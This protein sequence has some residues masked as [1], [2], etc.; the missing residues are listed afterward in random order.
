MHFF[1]YLGFPTTS[2]VYRNSQCHQ[3]R[4]TFLLGLLPEQLLS[5]P[6]AWLACPFLKKPTKDSRFAPNP[7]G[8]KDPL[9][10]SI[11]FRDKISCAAS[12]DGHIGLGASYSSETCVDSY[13]SRFSDGVASWPR[14]DLN[15]MTG[16]IVMM[17]KH[18]RPPEMFRFLL[19]LCRATFV[20]FISINLKT[21]WEVALGTG[22]KHRVT[23]IKQST[24]KPE[25]T[26]KAH[27][28]IIIN[29]FLLSKLLVLLVA[30]MHMHTT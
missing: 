13:R 21:W 20:P 10:T 26:D 5:R 24:K 29:N 25:S 12:E 9:A 16:N 28:R 23:T 30:S 2:L 14:I 1:I 11:S 17:I 6:P 8:S 3:P 18:E 22:K 15:L 27:K 4:P 7:R 19:P